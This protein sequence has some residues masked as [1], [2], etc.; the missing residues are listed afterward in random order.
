[1]AFIV[2]AGLACSRANESAA[3]DAG[4]DDAPA[5]AGAIDAPSDAGVD[6][7]SVPPPV[8]IVVFDRAGIGSYGSTGWTYV[9][10]AR[11][12]VDWKQ[13]PFAQVTLIVDLDSACYPF[14]KWSADR[15]PVGQ[16]WPADC[17][18]FDRNF[19]VFIDD[20]VPAPA[21]DAGGGSDTADGGA[22]D[23]GDGDGGPTFTPP[24]PA[25]AAR[26][27]FEVIH[28]ITPF[29]GPEHLEVDLTDL[30]NGLPGKHGLRVDIN[31]YPDPQGMV[32]GSNGGWTVS[33]RLE[34]T[35]GPA[36]RQVLAVVPLYQGT[37]GAA[38]PFPVV[39]WDVPPGTASGRLEYRTSGHGQGAQAARCTGPAEEFCDRRHQLFLDGAE[40]DNIEPWREDCQTLC[41][42]AHYG[43]PDAGF[44][45]CQEN[46][47][48]AV[49][50]VTAA[51]ANWCPGHMTPPFS[52]Q[53]LPALVAPG[54]HTFSFQI[55]NIVPGGTWLASAIYVAYGS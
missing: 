1:L 40:I 54:S 43:A 48:G 14:S 33:A 52:W 29:G 10:Q 26:T 53:D 7:P 13:G 39:S 22:G 36:P 4:S 18:A 46:P 3:R 2:L 11:A 31:S 15:P 50:S 38:D 49:D 25:S 9:G 44:D 5:D 41:T 27:P 8:T 34:V 19:N 24:M 47:C 16:S 32:T 17:D 21:S 12:D 51:R 20:T 45:Y 55:L 6:A 28:A 23:G 37:I 35:P 30:A 42:I